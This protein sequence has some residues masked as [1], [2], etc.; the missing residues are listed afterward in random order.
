MKFIEPLKE[1]EKLKEYLDTNLYKK[2]AIFFGHGLGDCVMFQI[3]LD[4]L[5]ELY[6]NISF[7]MALQKG[8]DEETIY[9]DAVFVNSREEAQK[10]EEFDLVAQI[11]FPVETDPHLTKAELCCKTEL[12]IEPIC[13]HKKLPDFPSPIVAVHFNLTALPSLA[14]PS[15]EVAEKIWREI[16]EAGLI[17]IECHFSHVFDNPVNKKFSFVDSTVRNC[18]AKVSSLIG[19]LKVSRAFIGV[20]S[21]PFHCALS[22]LPFNRILYLEKDLPLNRFTYEPI[23]T[24]DIKNYRDGF[25]K[26]WLVGI[27]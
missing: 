22:V 18:Q 9:P 26:E 19:L 16:K 2:V 14:N 13:G 27:A 20:V 10:L 4:K 6:P 12:G 3:L 7:T 21:G 11:N 17:P 25:V 8:L 1:K 23:K 24:L 15:E 5:K